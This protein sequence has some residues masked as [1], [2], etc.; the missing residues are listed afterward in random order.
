MEDNC[1]EIGI[2]VFTIETIIHE[3]TEGVIGDLIGGFGEI[4]AVFSDNYGYRHCLSHY[5]SP[6]GQNSFFSPCKIHHGK[7][8][9]DRK[10]G[11]G[12]VFF[13]TKLL[14]PLEIKHFS[15]SPKYIQ[16]LE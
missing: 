10:F 15:D 4:D 14:L 8:K 2:G 3:L 6:F 11:G 13:E 5:I 1:I 9:E 16:I 12:K 7:P